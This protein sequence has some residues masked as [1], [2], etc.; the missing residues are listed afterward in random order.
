MTVCYLNKDWWENYDVGWTK[1]LIDAQCW[2]ADEI[3]RNGK[4]PIGVVS[5]Y[6]HASF[7]PI[8]DELMA[9][10]LDKLKD[11]FPG[12]KV[13]SKGRRDFDPVADQRWVDIYSSYI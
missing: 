2:V 10:Q 13:W 12:V 11:Y 6:F 5:P 7:A 8:P 1:G 9:M 3:Y 4:T